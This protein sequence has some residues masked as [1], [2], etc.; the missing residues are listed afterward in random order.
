MDFI[1]T[2]VFFTTLLIATVIGLW[3]LF[4]YAVKKKALEIVRDESVNHNAM[5]NKITDGMHEMKDVFERDIHEIRNT[6][7]I[8]SLEKDYQQKFN[9]EVLKRIDNMEQMVERR[10]E[11]TE[12]LIVRQLEAFKSETKDQLA[13]LKKTIEK[14]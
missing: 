4:L 7:N 11:K 1:N 10:I 12:N 2:T 3:K 9:S 5:I 8:L 6:T 13:D 14:K